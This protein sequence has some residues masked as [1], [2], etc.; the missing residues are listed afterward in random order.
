M[1]QIACLISLFAALLIFGAAGA[2]D[3]V[4]NTEAKQMVATIEY[5]AGDYTEAV[6]FE[7]GKVVSEAEYSNFLDL[8]SSIHEYAKITGVDQNKPLNDLLLELDAAVRNKA[9]FLTVAR[10]AMTAQ[11]QLIGI[12]S[13]STFP[14]QLPDLKRGAELFKVGCAPCH[15]IDGKA[16]TPVA[17]TLKP[18]PRVFAD[19]EQMK[20]LSPFKAFNAVTYGIQGTLMPAF[21][22]YSESDRWSLASHVFTLR[23]DLPPPTN[24]GRTPYV[25][26]Q[27][28]T[29]LPDGELLRRFTAAGSDQAKALHDLSQIRHLK[30]PPEPAGEN[31]FLITQE[32]SAAKP[33]LSAFLRSIRESFCAVLLLLMA[34]VSLRNTVTGSSRQNL[35]PHIAWLSAALGSLLTWIV[36]RSS[37][38]G[39]LR[40]EIVGLALCLSAGLL[41]VV[42]FRP[43]AK[44]PLLFSASLAT[45]AFFFEATILFWALR[46]QMD[47]RG[48]QIVLGSFCAILALIA[49]GQA[50]G[51]VFKSLSEKHFRRLF[52]VTVLLVLL[53]ILAQGI[54][55]LQSAGLIQRL[56]HFSF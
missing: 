25:P 46:L 2:A 54:H 51:L 24:D 15:G 1:K 32:I 9:P 17:L 45:Y 12:F 47:A 4:G 38:T 20:R 35:L 8:L 26:W 19:P 41:S 22:S 53:L 5:I 16:N 42:I 36:V 29:S 7:G 14:D 52:K 39:T 21:P 13:I 34:S 33:F 28:A 30:Y 10:I 48:I 3:R 37:I 55:R 6:A 11:K 43:R 44:M 50:M 23:S 40:G 49:V 56:G 18:S 27:A 31:I